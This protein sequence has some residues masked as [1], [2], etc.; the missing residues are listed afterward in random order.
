MLIDPNGKNIQLNVE[1]WS[2]NIIQNQFVTSS[3]LAGY[4][5][6]K[7]RGS[8][9][10]F[11]C[12]GSIYGDNT[13][14]TVRYLESITIDD[15]IDVTLD[16]MHDFCDFELKDNRETIS[17]FISVES[18]K[19]DPVHFAV[20][21][22]TMEGYFFASDEYEY[23]TI[24]T[25]FG[26]QA[27]SNVTTVSGQ[28]ET[29]SMSTA[30]D[31][32]ENQGLHI[33]TY[34]GISLVLKA[35]DLLT[36]TPR[37]EILESGNNMAKWMIVTYT[38]DGGIIN[39]S[40]L[41][42]NRGGIK[43]ETSIKWTITQSGSTRMISN[44]FDGYYQL[45]TDKT[46]GTSVTLLASG[47]VVLSNSG[48]L[49]FTAPGTFETEMITGNIITIVSS[50]AP[51]VTG[52]SGG[53]IPSGQNVSVT[54]PSGGENFI[55]NGDGYIYVPVHF[56][57]NDG[58][59]V[60]S[61]QVQ[62]MGGYDPSTWVLGTILDNACDE[63][64][65]E[66]T[67]DPVLFKYGGSLGCYF[68]AA[69][70]K[71]AAVRVTVHYVT[72]GFWD[73]GWSQMT[74]SINQPYSL[75]APILENTEQNNNVRDRTLFASSG[76]IHGIYDLYFFVT[77]QWGKA[78]LNLGLYTGNLMSEAA[79]LSAWRSVIDNVFV[80]ANPSIGTGPDYS[81][82]C[83]DYGP[84]G[85]NMLMADNRDI[86]PDVPSTA[87][88]KRTILVNDQVLTNISGRFRNMGSGQVT[89]VDVIAVP[90]FSYTTG[91]FFV[92][93]CANAT[94]PNIKNKILIPK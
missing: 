9:R 64:Y 10:K 83:V 13:P 25:Y 15:V 91:Y 2:S 74:F 32:W 69:A 93:D 17:G 66:I 50:N 34:T 65:N 53:S 92:G 44:A 94:T 5:H 60:E 4:P 81:V 36:C 87:I 48:D 41:I 11:K 71:Y 37:L 49:T 45:S 57:I 35:T 31:T 68:S 16:I 27:V 39:I 79:I 24:P 56:T 59:Q 77:V 46:I 85:L 73:E 14:G 55:P 63:S 82:Y 67:V 54:N 19:I 78:N 6:S 1:D 47:V 90:V 29:L 42:I 33:A 62:L 76:L 70:T 86:D 21:G 12:T 28:N 61:I 22:Y 20:R 8:I 75:T 43:L 89:G 18:L 23:Y 80:A 7:F 51:V 40:Y 3:D 26:M 84:G 30:I 38:P 52:S 88:F 72:D 58:S